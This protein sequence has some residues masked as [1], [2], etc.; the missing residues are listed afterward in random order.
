MRER[1]AV[2]SARFFF[3]WLL[4]LEQ[5]EKNP[6]RSNM[7]EEQLLSAEFRSEAAL[8]HMSSSTATPLLLTK[9]KSDSIDDKSSKAPKTKRQRKKERED[10]KR[11]KISRAQEKRVGRLKVPK[12][13]AIITYIHYFA[14]G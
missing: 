13:Y 6:F 14:P 7:N 12:M 9:R 1:G 3:A 4:F 2:L 5:T 10:Q 8:R 11:L